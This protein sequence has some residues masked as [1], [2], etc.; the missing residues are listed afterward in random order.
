MPSSS[1]PV[2]GR[3]SASS[4]SSRKT[5]MDDLRRQISK[6]KADLEAERT[7]YRQL[8][9]DKALESKRTQDV[10]ER[11]KQKAIE[12]VTKRLTSEHTSELRKIRENVAKEKEN[13]LRQVLKFKDEEVKALK[14]Q[15]S[16]EKEKNRAAEE[17][18][19]SL[20]VNKSKDGEDHS[21][22]ERKLRSE[23]AVLKEQ[24]QKVEEM[25][26][27]KASAE[28]EHMELVRRMKVEHELE[29]QKFIKDS[30]RESVQSLQQRRLTEKALEEKEHELAFKDQLAR[31][32]E[33]EKDDLQRQISLTGELEPLRRS[34][35]RT[36]ASFDTTVF[37]RLDDSVS[38]M[39]TLCWDAR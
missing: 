26:R 12:L 1:I 22:I 8:V 15:V 10:V 35:L 23:I 14:Q 18:V 19:R 30:K 38:T 28:T 36:N 6:L 24:K 20:L 4:P 13:E 31:K 9:R 32:L 7:K 5:N 11:E 21:E 39:F 3:D 34:S 37:D 17:E 25:Y 33:A 27:L 16:E 2:P 29:L